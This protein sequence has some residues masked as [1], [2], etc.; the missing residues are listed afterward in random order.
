MTR[1]YLVFF[2]LPVAAFCQKD[3]QKKVQTQ[4]IEVED[5]KVIQLPQGTFHLV[6]SLW[7]DGKREVV[8][9]GAGMD[10]TILNFDGQISGAEGIKI[11]NSSGITIRDLTV[12]NTKGDAI[13]TQLVDGMTFRNVKA[14]WTG[15]PAR[16]NGGYGLYPV[17][18]SLVLI[19]SCVAVGASDAGIY[20]GQSIHIIV[21]N[22]TAHHNVAGIEI[23]NS[24][25]ADVYDNEVFNNTGGILIFD[26]PGLIRKEGGFIRVFA[27]RVHDNNHSNFAPRGNIVGKVPPGTGIM[28]LATRNVEVF[29]NRII[30]NITTG[31]AIVSYYM[32]EN[33]ITD[34]SYKPYPSN[35]NVHHNYYERPRVRATGKGR[36]GKL[37]RLKL[38]FGRDVPHILY[39]GIEDPGNKDPNICFRDNTNATFV[40]IDAGNGFRNK[41]YELVAY[42]CELPSIDPVVLEGKK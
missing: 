6:A 17:Q 30:N 23:E 1:L 14:E 18:C 8:I 27:N 28:I 7:L 2:F 4:F 5:G 13:K 29:N 41:S 21:R 34:I 16:E 19:D 32:T 39:D 36:M 38:R 24:L 22:S 35:I 11:T 20:V 25:Y 10:K 37:F 33:P 15:G 40:D 26:L 9:K 31:T 42:T 3:F 12:Q